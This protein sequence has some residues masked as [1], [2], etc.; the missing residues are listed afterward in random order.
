M[1][2][3]QSPEAIPFLRFSISKPKYIDHVVMCAD[4]KIYTVIF[5]IIEGETFSG[6]SMYLYPCHYRT[7][8]KYGN[9]V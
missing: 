9:M 4:A 7:S 5:K 8:P 1:S 3:T 6:I 2:F